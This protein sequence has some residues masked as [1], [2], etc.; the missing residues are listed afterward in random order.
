MQRYIL[1][2]L[3]HGVLT[4]FVVS[5]VVF[6]ISRA[7]GD[8]TYLLLPDEGSLTKEDYDMQRRRLGLDQPLPIQY[9]T[10]LGKMAQGDFGTSYRAGL[11]IGE[12]IGQ[13]LP[14]T[15]KLGVAALGFA[16]LLAL[17]LGIIAALKKDSSIDTA[18]KIVA[19]FG[20]AMPHFWLGIMLILIFSVRLGWLPTSGMGGPVHYLMPAFTLGYSFVAA[21]M[22]RLTRSSMLEVLDAEYMKLVRIKGVS[23]RRAILLHALRNAL[24]PVV[25]Y[26][27]LYFALFMSG[28]IVVET[29]FRWPGI[30]RLAYEATMWRDFPLLQGIVVVVAGITVMVHLMVDI[31]YAY[32]DP[33][34]RY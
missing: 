30:G 5:L 19:F 9:V 32:I 10:W 13:R 21:G 22:M 27:G 1:F 12:L 17:P 6:L 7:T 11:P 31:V 15:L 25:T 20:M 28:S 23:E 2:R 8:P 4:L 26:A 29:V 18:A 3:L 34:I 24:I 14:N 16:T 33:R